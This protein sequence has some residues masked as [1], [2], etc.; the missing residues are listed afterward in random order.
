MV[1]CHGKPDAPSARDCVSKAIAS[2]NKS[3]TIDPEPFVKPRK[4]LVLGSGGEFSSEWNETAADK[5]GFLP[6]LGGT[7]HQALSFITAH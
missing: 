4:V 1:R 6:L 3:F 5:F 2:I 7:T